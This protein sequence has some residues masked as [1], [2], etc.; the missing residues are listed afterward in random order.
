VYR[1][2]EKQKINRLESTDLI[3]PMVDEHW[4]SLRQAHERGQKVV[5][6]TGGFNLM[7]QSQGIP[8]HNIPGYA[9]Y[10]AGL[11]ESDWLIDVAEA[12]GQLPD[13]CSYH[14]NHMGLVT[15]LRDGRSPRREEGALPMPDL[16]FDY[17]ICAEHPHFID[18]IYRQ[19][20]IPVVSV[21]LPIPHKVSDVDWCDAYVERQLKELVVPAVERLT[22]RPYDYDALSERL[23]VFR[24]AAILRKECLDYMKY[25]PA[26]WTFVDICVS[27]APV[28]HLAG[29]PGTVEYY[30]KLKEELE[31]R[32]SQGIA[33]LPG[34]RYRLYWDSYM[35][36]R[37]LGLIT[38]KLAS[39]GG[40]LIAGRYPW[41]MG[42][43]PEDTD[44][45]QPLLSMA[46]KT[47]RETPAFRLMENAVDFIADSI[48]K[49]SIDGLIMHTPRTCR[50]WGIGQQ[51]LVDEIERK[52]GIPG[53]LIEADM[54]DPKFFS[55]AQMDT[56]LQA[57]CEMMEARK[58]VRA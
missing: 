51:V 3:R 56:K 33:A 1:V 26:P 30:Q 15:L 58:R 25:V 43:F 13:T 12:D 57:F 49:Y 16:M 36:W 55:E 7:T 45:E 19:L 50:M 4:E 18:S 27:L 39:L 44:P 24:K 5:W 2:E 48:E 21:D 52:C 46:R 8:T 9:T 40:I 38:R 41:V 42:A 28:V 54:M 34:E 47:N 37:W 53:V 6:A 11:Q 14:R 29:K 23:A 35:M 17:R 22:G 31:R 20:K 10:C 32:V